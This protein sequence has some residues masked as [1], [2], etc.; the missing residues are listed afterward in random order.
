MAI[1]QAVSSATSMTNTAALPISFVR[2]ARGCHSGDARFVR[3]SRA[4]FSSSVVSRMNPRDIRSARV[5][6]GS[7]RASASATLR[8]CRRVS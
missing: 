7:R 4:E 3:A 2:F 6:Q 8:I 1:A 5:C